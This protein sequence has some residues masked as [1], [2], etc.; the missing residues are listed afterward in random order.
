MP[1]EQAELTWRLDPSE[2]M[3]DWT[4]RVYN[5]GTKVTDEYHVHK[6]I[7]AVGKRRSEY[8][9]NVFRQRI[10]SSSN[11]SASISNLSSDS[12]VTEIAFVN[13]AASVIPLLL[14]FMYSS[15]SSSSQ[16]TTDVAPGLRFLSQFFGVRTLFDRVMRFIQRDL[17]LKTMASYYR[18]SRELG[19]KKIANLVAKHCARNIHLIDTAHEII[20]VGDPEFF[21]KVLSSPG[22]MDERKLHMSLLVTK[23]CQ[24][25]RDRLNSETFLAITHEHNLPVVHHTAAISLMGM[26][27]DLIVPTS[28][29]EMSTTMTN[30]QERCIQGLA[31]HWRALTEQDPEQT[32]RVC[33]KL[34]SLVVTELM[35]RSLDC[36]KKEGDRQAQGVGLARN[37]KSPQKGRSPKAAAAA[38]AA[39]DGAKTKTEH[40][41]A[42]EALKKEY[43]EKLKHL[44]E[45]CYEKDKHINNYYKELVKFARLPNSTEGK[46]IKSGSKEQPTIMP[47]IGKHSKEGYLLAGKKLGGAKYPLFYYKQDE[48]LPPSPSM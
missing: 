21:L 44:Q 9:V 40:E 16:L 30:L 3:S 29:V 46:M 35:L 26:E 32:A 48:Q 19:D 13:R 38:T 34:P 43:E 18:A 2:S 33:R 11:S 23:F 7:L 22:L 47:S 31:S 42:L 6:N 1:D 37:A 10:K 20:Q 36:A 27:A 8:F 15:S 5:R 24:L 28:I 17:N 4:I 39:A 12:A 45:V 25:H 14:D 41:A